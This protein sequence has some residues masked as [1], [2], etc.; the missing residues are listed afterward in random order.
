[1]SS[2]T[3]D[4]SQVTDLEKRRLKLSVK[5]ENLAITPVRSKMHNKTTEA[6][7]SAKSIAKPRV[8]LGKSRSPLQR[9][10]V[11]GKKL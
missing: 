10:G 9:I 3:P 8:T 5:K 1:M 6:F 2:K 4:R 7:R 11:N